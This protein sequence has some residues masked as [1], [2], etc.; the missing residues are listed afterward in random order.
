MFVTT[1][2][3][4][5]LNIKEYDQTIIIMHKLYNFMTLKVGI[6]EPSKYNLLSI[7]DILLKTED[8]WRVYFSN[9]WHSGHL[10]ALKDIEFDPRL[11]LGWL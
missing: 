1:Y 11:I 3:L 5:V 4:Q 9:L 2:Q 6:H 7:T 10:L 8:S